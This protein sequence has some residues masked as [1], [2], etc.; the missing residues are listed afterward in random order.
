MAGVLDRAVG[1]RGSVVTVV[2]SR[3][4]Q[5][6]SGVRS[7][8]IGYRAGVQVFTT[9]CDS[10]TTQVPFHVV[11]RLLRTVFGVSNLDAP[12]AGR[13]SAPASRALTPRI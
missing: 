10:H 5:E 11:A 12:T 4:R 6:P 3:G 13:K 1:G 2:G 7:S 9:H 8:R